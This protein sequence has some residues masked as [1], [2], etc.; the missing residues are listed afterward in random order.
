[1][2]GS[3][4]NRPVPPVAVGSGHAIAARDG[5]ARRADRRNFAARME[6]FSFIGDLA[7]TAW[8]LLLAFWIRFGTNVAKIGLFDHTVTLNDY[9]GHLLIGV[10]LMGVLL[11]NFR[12]YNPQ[13]LLSL[14]YVSQA[15]SKASIA[16]IL[17][18]MCLSF[19]LKFEP[20]ISRL[21]C[22]IGFAL[23]LIGLLTW[24]VLLNR[25]IRREQHARRLRE[26]VLMVGWNE[27]SRRLVQL[28]TSG[29]RHT[30]EFAGVVAPPHGYAECEPEDTVIRLGEFSDLSTI[31]SEQDVDV[32]LVS[33][34][35]VSRDDLT[36]L[37]IICE[38]E[39]VDFKIVPNCFQILLSG[40]HLESI[41]GVPVL[42]VSR[43]PLHSAF[44]QYLKRAVD[45]FGGTIGLVLSAPIIAGFGLTVWLQSRG[46]VFYKQVRIGRDGK[47]FDIWKIRSMR[48]DSESSGVGWTVKGDPRLLPIGAI[49]RKLNI[50]EVPQFWNVIKGEMSLVGPRPERPELI[51]NLKEIIPHYQVRHDVKPGLTG[52]AQINGYRGDTD[53]RER[54]KCD[55][56][57]IENWNLFWDFQIMAMTFVK[58]GGAC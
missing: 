52:W 55:L 3:I 5:L 28:I 23:C 18:F 57:Y 45:L 1:M 43:L 41:S 32:V 48:L 36:S 29:T 35:G 58:R 26:R 7:V 50:D 39:M 54:I 33:D 19:I 40:L 37:S 16:W 30:F 12:T 24:R 49:M 8:M 46:P 51:Q 17:C 6:V 44:N 21:Y 13:H 27:E 22:A 25:L 9:L 56:Y 34:L 53:L 47:P 38:K 15:I 2:E 4:S 14:G 42:G 11:A 10:A 20:S 31:I